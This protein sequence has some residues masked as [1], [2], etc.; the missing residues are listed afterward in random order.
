MLNAQQRLIAARSSWI[1]VKRQRLEN[2]INLH[3]ALGGNFGK[4]APA[5]DAGR[6]GP[7]KAAAE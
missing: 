7:G 3:L 2:R 6:K 5:A 1:D 4:E